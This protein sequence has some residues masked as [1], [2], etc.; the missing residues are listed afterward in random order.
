MLPI[1]ETSNAQDA[2]SWSAMTQSAG[3]AIGALGPILVGWI[4]DMTHSMVFAFVGLAV[5]CTAMIFVQ[6]FI[7]SNK[8][9]DKEVLA[10]S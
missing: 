4:Q 2:S 7:G 6:L 8:G 9:Q 3:Y 10:A 1:D 5:I